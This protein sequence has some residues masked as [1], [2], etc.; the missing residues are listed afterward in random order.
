ME[1]LEFFVN[2]AAS[3]GHDATS[4]LHGYAHVDLV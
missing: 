4:V 1:A 3:S 2:S